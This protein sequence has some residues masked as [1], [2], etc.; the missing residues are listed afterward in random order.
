LSANRL[1]DLFTDGGQ[2]I[3]T[4]ALEFFAQGVFVETRLTLRR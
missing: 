3:D 4:N 2:L 1:L